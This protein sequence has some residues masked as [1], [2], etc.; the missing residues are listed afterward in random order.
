MAREAEQILMH[1]RGLCCGP[2]SNSARTPTDLPLACRMTPDRGRR[3]PIWFDEIVTW[4]QDPTRADGKALHF[5]VSGFATGREIRTCDQLN[6][7]RRHPSLRDPRKPAGG[8][9]VLVEPRTPTRS[10]TRRWISR[11]LGLLHLWVSR[12][13]AAA[14]APPSF[15]KQEM[16]FWWPV[17]RC[18]ARPRPRPKAVR[19]LRLDGTSITSQPARINGRMQ[20]KRY[21]A[22]AWPKVDVPRIDRQFWRDPAA[23]RVPRGSRGLTTPI[24]RPQ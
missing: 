5:M 14:T 24:A 20:A 22:I 8:I 16:T 10:T 1:R 12:F 7:H 2:R 3:C 21:S 6:G 23:L 17:K 4:W 13:G 15:R 11:R 19:R 18:G 9:A